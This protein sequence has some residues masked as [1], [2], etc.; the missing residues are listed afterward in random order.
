VGRRPGSGTHDYVTL[1]APNWLVRVVAC[2]EGTVPLAIRYRPSI[3]FARTRA[4]VERTPWGILVDRGPYLY[5]DADF[6]VYGDVAEAESNMNAGESISFV[7]SPTLLETP[8]RGE[9]IEKLLGITRA[10]WTEWSEYCRYRGRYSEHVIRSALTLKLLTY[11]PSGGL[12]A[13]PTCSLPEAIGGER[14]WD[15][16]YCWLRDATFTLYA[17]SALGYSGE[18]KDFAAYLSHHCGIDPQ[19]L[20]VMYGIECETQLTEHVLDHLEGYRGS[21][22]VRVGNAA[23]TQTQLDVYGELLDWALLYREL[24]GRFTPRGR[25][26][27]QLLANIVSAHWQGPGQG[28]WEMRSEPR[29]YVYSRMMCWAAMDRAIKLFGEKDDWKTMRDEIYESILRDGIDPDSGALRQTL[30]SSGADAAL[31]LAPEIGFPLS[32]DALRATIRFVER[33]LRQGDYVHRYTCADG[34][35]GSEGAFLICSF[36]LVQAKLHAGEYDDAKT[37]YERLI[38]CS[39]DVGLFSEEV[40]PNTHQFLGNFPQAFTHLALVLCAIDFDLYEEGGVQA[41][42]GTHADRARSH[43]EATEGWRALWAT[44]KR[45]G[46]VMRIFPSRASTMD[47]ALYKT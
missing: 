3:E 42:S 16:R 23:H 37:L 31:L 15:Y 19:E 38:S 40:D 9:R 26:R 43:V 24:G 12:V 18:A 45:T 33:E 1:N 46:R 30:S 35:A 29:H 6:S 27:F 2:K 7:V 32:D 10:F 14:N 13:A 47:E 36:W 34:I 4:T 20:Q 5:A 39:N 28:I 44:F 25:E 11:S 22:P 41:L 8:P 21:R 17:L